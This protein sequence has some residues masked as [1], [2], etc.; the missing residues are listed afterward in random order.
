MP[1]VI[2]NALTPVGDGQFIILHVCNNQGV[3]GAGFA[4]ALAKLWPMV[5]N[6]FH[7]WHETNGFNELGCVHYATVRLAGRL[8]LVANMVAQTLEGHRFPLSMPHLEDCLHNINYHY[9]TI[10]GGLHLPRIGSGLARGHWADIA[11]L[12]PAHWYIYTL[13]QEL[14]RFPIESRYLIAPDLQ[15]AF[16][17]RQEVSG[18]DAVRLARAVVRGEPVEVEI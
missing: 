18:A 10:P 8:G 13:P 2:G 9:P 6:E 5:A 15:A 17:Y 16:G 3:M 11:E 7:I 4:L 1:H 12:I 14:E